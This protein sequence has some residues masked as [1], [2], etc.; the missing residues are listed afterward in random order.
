M[1]GSEGGLVEIKLFNLDFQ[2]NDVDVEGREDLCATERVYKLLHSRIWVIVKK[3]YH[4]ESSLIDSKTQ[5]SIF[6]GDEEYW[7]GSA[8]LIDKS[9][10]IY[11]FSSPRALQKDQ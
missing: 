1:V 8:K 11:Y 6:L 10:L 3:F 4:I 5:I 2:I 7:A 9:M